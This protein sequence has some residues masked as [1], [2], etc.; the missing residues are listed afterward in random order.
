MTN[1][2]KRFESFFAE[3][4]ETIEHGFERWGYWVFDRRWVVLIGSLLLLGSL[5]AQIPFLK[6]DTSTEGFL[7]EE[8]PIRQVYNKFR[9]QFGRDERILIVIDSG[10]TIFS[11]P[12]LEK[13]RALHQDLEA[14]VPKLQDV[15]SLVNARL[16]RGEG[17]EL[18]V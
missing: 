17:D 10:S 9:F 15:K 14:H 6:V 3:T 13:L 5:I 4:R 8:D 12:F 2:I 18:I 11:T 1:P 7:R 16:T